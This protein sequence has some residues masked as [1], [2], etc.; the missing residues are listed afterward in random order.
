[1]RRPCQRRA[2]VV[3]VVVAFRTPAPGCG[4][5][6]LLVR[7]KCPQA[8]RAILALPSRPRGSADFEYGIRY[9]HLPSMEHDSRQEAVMRQMAMWIDH[10]EARVFH[11]D[12]QTF[13]ES[14]VRSADRHVH[15]HP[16][17]QN[18]RTRNH[19]HDEPAFF[20]EALAALAGADET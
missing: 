13:D 14:T 4:A 3:P 17:D 5:Q 7:A 15:R 18:T 2:L 20:D 8:L 1:M 12:G 10:D 11:V 19:P 9:A 16:K 6:Y